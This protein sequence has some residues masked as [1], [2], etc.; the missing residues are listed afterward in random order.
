MIIFILVGIIVASLLVALAWYNDR[1]YKIAVRELSNQEL[2]LKNYAASIE[3]DK[4]EDK[5]IYDTNLAE[6]VSKKAELVSY[7]QL[8]LERLAEAQ[9]IYDS[10]Q[11]KIATLK[12][13]INKLQAELHNARQ[14]AKRLAKKAENGV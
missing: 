7:N 2:F 12:K 8:S 10:V 13:Q 4:Q 14:R 11:N 6:I 3:K 1:Q 5:K 9:R